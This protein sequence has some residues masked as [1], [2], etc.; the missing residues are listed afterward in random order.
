MVIKEIDILMILETKLDDSFPVSQVFV[1]HLELIRIKTVVGFF[2][3]S[4]AI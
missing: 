4:E 2:F 3:I 1:H